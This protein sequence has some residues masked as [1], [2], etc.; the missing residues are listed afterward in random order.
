MI[1]SQF[2]QPETEQHGLI[3]KASDLYSE[4]P[5]SNLGRATDYPHQVSHGFP[6]YFQGNARIVL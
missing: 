1:C 3:G 6:Q 5:G 4:V 2:L